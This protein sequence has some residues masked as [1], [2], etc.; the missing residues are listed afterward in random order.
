MVA[1]LSLWEHLCV[2]LNREVAETQLKEYKW[3]LKLIFTQGYLAIIHR[4]ASKDRLG[5][6]HRK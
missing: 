6:G 4:G 3:F 2:P 1:K 5:L